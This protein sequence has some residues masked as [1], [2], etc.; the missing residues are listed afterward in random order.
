MGA[1]SW[2]TALAHLIGTNGRQVLLWCHEE[3]VAEGIRK[4]RL[5]P[6]YLSD[7]RLPET[8]TATVSA[9]EALDGAEAVVCVVPTQFIRKV[10]RKVRGHVAPGTCIVTASKGIEKKTLLTPSGIL[11]E[12]FG[13]RITIGALSGP[14][15]AKEVA[16][17]KPTAVTLAV[18]D[19]DA[20]E[21][22]Q[23]LFTSPYFRVY[24]HHDLI[25][26]E[27]GGALKNVMA[28]AAGISDGLGLGH[29][30]RAAL[31][32]RGLQEMIRLGVAMGADPTT[33]SGLS[34]LGDLVLTAAGD[35]SRN[36]RVGLELGRGRSLKQILDDMNMVAEGVAT[37]RSA[38]DL[39]AK[40]DVE[41]PI[42]NEVYRVLYHRR[43]PE[44]AVRE[45]MSR[46][47]KSEFHGW[48]SAG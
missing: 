35:L 22:L 11:T 36:R 48:T 39:S 15:F 33:F 5:N 6:R 30:A 2:G 43:S 45:L 42:V 1:G 8:V 12:L 13:D 24:T 26:A 29:S 38:R 10:F 41:M 32:T 20:A 28:I 25:G 44:T 14:S 21:R 40:M 4:K 16:R 9:R 47:P 23:A 46:S 34:G 7:I 27:L 3:E 31:I 37:A 17:L 18:D 19:T